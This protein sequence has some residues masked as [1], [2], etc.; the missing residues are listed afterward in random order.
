MPRICSSSDD[1]Q[2]AWLNRIASLVKKSEVKLPQQAPA[3]PLRVRGLHGNQVK[4]FRYRISKLPPKILRKMAP[5]EPAILHRQSS[6]WMARLW[7]TKGQ[8]GA[9]REMYRE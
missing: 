4:I 5:A 2:K 9:I 3:P 8:P 1:A 6:N 7:P